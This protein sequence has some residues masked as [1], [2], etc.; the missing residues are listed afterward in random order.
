M[1]DDGG[2]LA[3][4][5]RGLRYTERTPAPLTWGGSGGQGSRRSPGPHGRAS[6]GKGTACPVR[7][8]S[9]MAPG[10]VAVRL[11]P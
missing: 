1:Q 9:P 7:L 11:L 5:H 6:A 3:C 4:R 2:Q 10:R 8:Q